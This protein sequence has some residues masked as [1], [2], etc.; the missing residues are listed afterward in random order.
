[1]P[2]VGF[3]HTVPASAWA[4]TVYTLS[5]LLVRIVG[6]GVQT[7]PT[8]HVRHL[9]AYC[10]C[11][12]WL[13]GWRIWWNE[14]W[15]G[16]LKYSEKTCPSATL[17]ITNPTWPDPGS[18]PGRR[19]GKPATNRLSYGAACSSC[20][21]PLGYRDRRRTVFMYVHLIEGKYLVWSHNGPSLTF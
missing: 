3:E 5:F 20:F 13:W 12:G 9:L 2:W 18:N 14:D 11:P 19:V 17:S 21:R 1:M 16:K 6:G 10:S 4:K 8:R 7:G 15:Q